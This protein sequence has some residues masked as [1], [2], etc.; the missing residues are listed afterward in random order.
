MDHVVSIVDDLIFD[1]N[2]K[3]ALPLNEE[4]LHR[5]CGNDN[6]FVGIKEGCHYMRHHGRKK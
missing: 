3:F 5:C 2:K 6:T 4:N 1:P